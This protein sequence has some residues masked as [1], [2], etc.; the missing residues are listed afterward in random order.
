MQQLQIHDLDVERLAT[1]LRE[2]TGAFARAV[3]G[4]D[5]H[6]PVPTCPEWRVRDLVGHIGQAHR[7]SAELVR[8]RAAAPVPDPRAAEPGAPREWPEWLRDGADALVAAVVDGGPA[9]PVWTF[10]DERPAAFW[11]RRML[12]DTAVHHADAA[13]AAR[14]DF[15]IAPDL[16]A[17]TI[18]EG[19]GLIAAAGSANLQPALAELRGDGETLQLRPDDLG[20]G[21][22]ITRTPAGVIWERRTA[23]A[24]VTVSGAVR[25]LLLVFSRR[26][27]PDDDRI[28]ITGDRALLDHWWAHTAF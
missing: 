27:D 1:G 24:D 14:V 15:A 16:A 11:L 6:A 20:A 18:S 3:A 12:A 7:W 21:W 4:L 25:D 10:L 28:T 22:L 2:E 19:L 5:P 17:D 8:T 9:T 23:D 13:G 26:T